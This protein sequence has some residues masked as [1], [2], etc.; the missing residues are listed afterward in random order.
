MGSQVIFKIIK[1]YL[2]NPCAIYNGVLSG[3]V[4]C[5]ESCV[6]CGGSGCGNRSGGVSNCCR[7]KIPLQQI[8][9][10]E[11]DAPCRLTKGNVILL[12]SDCTVRIIHLGITTKSIMYIFYYL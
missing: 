4:C 7:G 1:I 11:Q 12:K 9:G 2:E 6:T 5:A 3:N 8:C 10:L